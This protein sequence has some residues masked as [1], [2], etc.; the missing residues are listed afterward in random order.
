MCRRHC[1]WCCRR[2]LR[3]GSRLRGGGLH[4][5]LR[6]PQTSTKAL[7]L[8]S[9]VTQTERLPG[10]S[11]ASNASARS[12]SCRELVRIASFEDRLSTCCL[13]Q[14]TA[15]IEFPYARP[16]VACVNLTSQQKVIRSSASR[17]AGNWGSLMVGGK[18]RPMPEGQRWGSKRRQLARGW[19]YVEVPRARVVGMASERTWRQPGTPKVGPM[20]YALARYIQSCNLHIGDTWQAKLE[21]RVLQVC[22]HLGLTS[23]EPYSNSPSTNVFRMKGVLWSLDV[24]RALAVTLVCIMPLPGHLISLNTQARYGAGATALST[25]REQMYDKAKVRRMCQST[26]VA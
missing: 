24:P 14:G 5:R 13:Y 1:I 9:E 19:G 23:S 20:H 12:C 4:E 16:G 18:Y 22:G 6:F 25:E 7:D 21:S 10:S 15:V 17:I 8:V 2:D 26:S 11:L 3:W